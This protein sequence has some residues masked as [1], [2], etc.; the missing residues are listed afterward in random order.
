MPSKSRKQEVIEF[1]EDLLVQ[2][3]FFL[4][5]FEDDLGIFFIHK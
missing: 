4:Q 2:E 5:T 1:L 3:L